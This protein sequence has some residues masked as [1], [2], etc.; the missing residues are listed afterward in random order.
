MIRKFKQSDMESV[1]KIW[2]DSSIKAHDFIESNFWESN[3]DDMREIYI[4]SSENY[5]YEKEG[6]IKG[7]ISLYGD[8]VAAL[9]VSPEIQRLGIGTSLIKRAKKI[10]KSLNLTVYKENEKSVKFY[11]N[12]GFKIIKE[13]IDKNTGCL[14]LLMKYSS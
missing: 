5:I 7:F 10:H 13:Q 14:E 3:K 2:L 12:N 6:N 4:P 9:F 11:I 8:T 1:L